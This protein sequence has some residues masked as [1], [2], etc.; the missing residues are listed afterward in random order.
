M[1]KTPRDR[2]G[3]PP[4]PVLSIKG[5]LVTAAIALGVLALYHNGMLGIIPPLSGAKKD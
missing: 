5:V 1:G 3:T 2:A 4:E